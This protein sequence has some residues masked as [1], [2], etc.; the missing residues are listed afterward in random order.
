MIKDVFSFVDGASV[1]ESAEEHEGEAGAVGLYEPQSAELR[2]FS[3]DF[4]RECFW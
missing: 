2:S 3:Q 1:S 4:V